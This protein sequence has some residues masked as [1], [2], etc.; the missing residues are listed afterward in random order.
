MDWKDINTNPFRRFSASNNTYGHALVDLNK[1]PFQRF[2]GKK[3]YKYYLLTRNSGT[4][5]Q[6]RLADFQLI[7]LPMT[8]IG[9]TL[10]PNCFVDFLLIIIPID[11]HWWNLNTK[12]FRRFFANNITN[13]HGLEGH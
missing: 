9:G 11:M 4:L 2:S 10:T 13:G 8:C 3:Y 6:N 7:L 5:S 1:K 12:P